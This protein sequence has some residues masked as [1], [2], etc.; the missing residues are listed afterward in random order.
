MSDS[1]INSQKAELSMHI[2]CR[3]SKS[4]AGVY[5]FQAITAWELE[6]TNLEPRSDL[7]VER[8]KNFQSRQILN[9]DKSQGKLLHNGFDRLLWYPSVLAA[10]NIAF[11]ACLHQRD[12][13]QTL[14]YSQGPHTVWMAYPLG[15]TAESIVLARRRLYPLF[16]IWKHVCVLIREQRSYFGKVVWPSTRQIIKSHLQSRF[17]NSCSSL[18]RNRYLQ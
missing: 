5:R 2:P 18:K 17:C 8:G 7:D 6:C 4:G 13:L 15:S 11:K 14:L 1:D 3:Q 12:L 16:C 9:Q 10:V